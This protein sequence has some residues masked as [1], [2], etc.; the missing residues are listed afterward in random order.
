MQFVD[1]AGHPVTEIGDYFVTTSANKEDIELP[2]SDIRIENGKGG[3]WTMSSSWAGEG[4]I[5]SIK[6]ANQLSAATFDPTASR[7][8]EPKVSRFVPVDW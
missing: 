1:K 2:R 3:F 8:T 7:A 4:L 5:L 6:G